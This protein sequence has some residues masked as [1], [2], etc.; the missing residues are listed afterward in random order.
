MGRTKQAGAGQ[1]T[2]DDVKNNAPVKFWI[3][4]ENLSIWS[5]GGVLLCSYGS[6][7]F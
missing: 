6:V 5:L 3:A 4:N 1:R 7:H 2:F